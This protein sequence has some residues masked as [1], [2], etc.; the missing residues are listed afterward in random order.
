VIAVRLT[1][2]R[3]CVVALGVLVGLFALEGVSAQAASVHP[4][5]SQITETPAG[6]FE[7]ADNVAVDPA[8]QDVYIANLVGE[9]GSISIFNS[10][11]VYQSQITS[12]NALGGVFEPT[13]V[14]VSDKTGDVYVTNGGGDNPSPCVYVFNALGGYV[15]KII[16]TPSEPFS[17]G[18]RGIAVDQSSGDFYV[19]D[20]FHRAVYRFNSVNAYQSE[21]TV[22]GGGVPKGVATDSSGDVYVT[23]N[24]GV[25]EFNS[26][27]AQILH[28][29]GTPGGSFN[30]VGPVAVDSEGNIYVG[31]SVVDEF[32][33]S[34]RF[35]DETSGTQ[36][37][38]DTLNG[39]PG[40][41]LRGS[42]GVAVNAAKDL[43]VAE[44][45]DRVDVFGPPITVP[46]VSTE[47]ATAGASHTAEVLH[48]TVDPDGIEVA[49]C[50]FEYRTEAEPAYGRHSVACSSS[51]GS[52]SA[53]VAVTAEASSL[54]PATTY[55]YRI[56]ASNVKGTEGGTNYG[57]GVSFHVIGSPRIESVS[58]E[59]PGGRAGQTHTTLRAQI[60][61]EGSETTYN[62]EYGESESYGSTIP[63]PAGAIGA[64]LKPVSVTAELSGLKVGTTYHYRVSAS[65]EFSPTPVAS[66]DQT[67]TT[68]P[69]LLIDSESAAGVTA[70][71][72]TLQAQINPLGTETTYYFQYGTTEAYGSEVPAPPGLSLGS[73][74]GDIG[75]SVHLQGLSPGTTYHYRVVAGNALRPEVPGSDG[76]FTTQAAGT[77]VGLP[78]GREWELVTPPNKQGAGFYGV[79][80]KEG[81]D[82]QAAADGGAI[83]YIASA[84]LV[85]S[86]AG[87]RGPEIEQML[88]T[89]EA[90]GSWGTADIV[91]PHDEV[92]PVRVGTI[93]EYMLFSSDLSLGLV[94]PVGDTPLPPL[95]A[96]SEKT[97]YFREASGAYKALVTSANVPPGTEFG[98][99]TPFEPA[100]QFAS[101]SPDL[102]H[103]VVESSVPL[104]EGVPAVQELYEWSEGRLQLVSVLPG[105][106]GKP[107]AAGGPRLGANGTSREG[108]V[109]HAISNDGSRIVW[110][111]QH[112]GQTRTLYLRDMARRETVQVDA[113]REVPEPP[114]GSDEARYWTANGEG[115]R[116]F[117]TSPKRL[118]TSST[119]G[120]QG[121]LY[122]FEVTSGAEEP[123]KG[124]LTDLTVDPHA[125]ETAS[126][127]GVIGASEDGSYVYF[128]ANGALGGAAV[129]GGNNLYMEHYEEATKTW[130]APTFIASLS[131][132]DGNTWSI[133]T[134]GSE[135]LNIM[136]SRVSPNGRYLAFMSEASLTGYENRDASSGVPDQ[137]VFLYDASSGRLVCTSC[138]PTGARPLGVDVTTGGL[139]EPFWDEAGLWEG[140][141]VAGSVPGWT[142]RDLLGALYQSRYLSDSGRLFFNSSDALVPA[143]VNGQVDVYEYEPAGEHA[144]S[145]SSTSASVVYSASAGG[146]VGL[147]SAGTSSQESAF[148]DA[149]ETGGD[150]FFLT[151]SQ[152]SP[153][154]YDQSY[155]IYDAHE[156]TA[157][158]PCAPPAPLSRPPCTTGDACKAAPTPQPTL[159]G[160]PSSET[161]S[162][163]GNVAPSPP[164]AKPATKSV[165]CKKNAVRK[166]GVCVR[167]R[168]VRAKRARKANR[169]VGR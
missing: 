1:R 127:A 38:S 52:G 65:N 130:A 84:P 166:H 3:A 80:A 144:C 66:A 136:T 59:V 46:D 146:C 40:G 61:P 82:I 16:G 85:T 25:Y 135:D 32:D 43:Y 19:V 111:L 60:N 148:L 142:P 156:C 23:E 155:D 138:D 152:L 164:A 70:T 167:K 17:V 140:R 133:D 161:F 56:V 26:S 131:S 30:D 14:A 97:I 89:R 132:G 73:G 83:T 114:G 154:D 48:G 90:P 123:L 34:S 55:Y 31:A 24:A 150:V 107:A 93:A 169:R 99:S 10:S 137:E 96:G 124:T 74:E 88:S 165:K 9:V 159:F 122:V 68:G 6:P 139:F 106:E 147:I 36:E 42:T 104:E 149:S 87:S 27:G 113:A 121:D 51:P 95:P 94:E 5:L 64:G 100:V 4:Y 79:G 67:F 35:V 33:S 7:Y 112:G 128:V 125:G 101:A 76:T 71:S 22:P 12:A 28:L 143:D 116:V 98:G 50:V 168:H 62:F 158:Q 86:S 119:E 75:V 108:D 153:Q 92:A 58:A 160:A 81:G 45:S 41:P 2:N 37:T 115:S 120:G 157:A 102:K 49:S 15:T 151:T 44:S 69:A 54:T 53:P 163:A 29:T 63:I 18:L 91:T 77:E 57:S 129:K 145:P 78:D 11:G 134:G 110:Q 21:L 126:V 141:W 117:F 109:R 47:V 8:S 72:V 105:P 103:V 162:G 118:T 39:P 20:E 13:G